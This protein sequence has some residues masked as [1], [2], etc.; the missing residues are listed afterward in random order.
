MCV[1]THFMDV[2]IALVLVY[3]GDTAYVCMYVYVDLFD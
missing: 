2:F 3:K 1:Y